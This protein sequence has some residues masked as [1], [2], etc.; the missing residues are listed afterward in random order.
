MDREVALR[1]INTGAPLRQ[2]A[3]CNFGLRYEIQATKMLLFAAKEGRVFVG[4]DDEKDFWA[5]DP[6][7]KKITGTAVI[8]AG[9]EYAIYDAEGDRIFL[10]IKTTDTLVVAGH[11]S[12][13]CITSPLTLVRRRLMPL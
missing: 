4:H 3:K 10:N 11:A 12:T 7:A 6:V 1:P 13:P 2:R 8:G 5:I 9:P